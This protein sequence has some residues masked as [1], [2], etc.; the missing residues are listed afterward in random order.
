MK[1]KTSDEHE[2]CPQLGVT[3]ILR[4]SWP[5]S[6]CALVAQVCT[7]HRQFLSSSYAAYSCVGSVARRA[8]SLIFS[9]HKD[10]STEIA[11]ASFIETS[12][13]SKCARTILSHD[14][15]SRPLG[16]LQSTVSLAT[17]R[18]RTSKL[19]GIRIIWPKRERCLLWMIVDRG[20]APVR[21]WISTL[22]MK[23]DHRTPQICRMTFPPKGVDPSL[24]AL[25]WCSCLWAVEQYRNDV[26]AVQPNFCP[27][28]N[29][30]FQ[31]A[32]LQTFKLTSGQVRFVAGSPSYCRRIRELAP[33]GIETPRR[34]QRFG[35]ALFRPNCQVWRPWEKV[36]QGLH[37]C[38]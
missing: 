10:L 7:Q 18:L 24:L 37:F 33:P 20:R 8:T 26:G 16:R 29:T 3:K 9:L 17:M 23:S 6:D 15:F 38:F 27:E 32:L 1:K 30:G 12:M 31:D 21:R 28:G 14:D 35:S 34:L 36:A 19:S 22:G 4:G 13:A 2:L 25:C 11:M 5:P